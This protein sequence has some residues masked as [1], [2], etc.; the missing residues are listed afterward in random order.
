MRIRFR[1]LLTSA[2]CIV[3][4]GIFSISSFAG[5]AQVITSGGQTENPSGDIIRILAIGNS[6]SEDAVEQNLYELF[7]AAG[8]KVII[9][10][11]YI[12]G[13]TL[14]RHWK[15][16]FNGKADYR[17]RKIADG[18]TTEIRDTTL[19]Y[20]L[21]DEPWDII[22]LQQ[23]SGVSGLWESY[24]PYLG[25][26]ISWL[27]ENAPKKDFKLAWHQTWAYSKDSTHKKFPNYGNDQAKMYNA[28]VDCV[29]TLMKEYHFD[30]LIPSGTA[31]QNARTSSLGD[32]FNRDGYHLERTYGRYTAACTWFEAIS[33]K[34][35]VGNSYA[36]A[37]VNA[38]QKEIAQEA[39]HLAVSKPYEVTP[40]K[41][42]GKTDGGECKMCR[43]YY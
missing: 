12:G 29:K 22:S 18:K 7:E 9:G 39:A 41:D 11:L 36:P 16:T 21:L 27:R 13:C 37:S 1:Y 15:N 24:E 43:E 35:V 14:Q 32:T 34:S 31:I 40:I 5:N 3:F 33:G 20:G 30:I 26:L 38:L 4:A 17:Y 28:I 23:S 25:N 2:L 19:L 42:C 6:F 10:N 8:Q